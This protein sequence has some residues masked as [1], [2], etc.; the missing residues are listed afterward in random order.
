MCC[1][2][3]SRLEVSFRA[4]TTSIITWRSDSMR[5]KSVTSNRLTA[6]PPRSLPGLR[7]ASASNQR[8]TPSALRSRHRTFTVV[9]RFAFKR[10]RV[11]R[12]KSKSSS[13]INSA[14]GLPTIS[15]GGWPRTVC[16]AGLTKSIVPS[17]SNTAKSSRT[18]SNNAGSCPLVFIRTTSGDGSCDI[19]CR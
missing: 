8:Q 19:E 11:A 1:N 5:C 14:T 13:W 15:S 10:R 6:I 3:W 7:R 16:I 12:N 17:A 4:W 18:H 2:N 9:S